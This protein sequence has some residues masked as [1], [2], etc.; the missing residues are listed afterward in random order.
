MDFI[1]DNISTI[2]VGAIV[3]GI[4]GL[5]LFRLIRSARRGK[6]ICGCGNCGG[7]RPVPLQNREPEKP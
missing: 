4:L 5:A 3:F 6:T 7:C 2:V 1:R